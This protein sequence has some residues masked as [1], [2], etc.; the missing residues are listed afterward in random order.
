MDIKFE[1]CSRIR[2]VTGS[3]TNSTKQQR[4]KFPKDGNKY[5]LPLV[6][7]AE[8]GMIKKVAIPIDYTKKS[9]W[10]LRPEF[11]TLY[12]T[13]LS[14]TEILLQIRSILSGGA[15]SSSAISRFNASRMAEF[16]AH[17]LPESF[18]LRKKEISQL[19]GLTNF[20]DGT[21]S[22][23]KFGLVEMRVGL[24]IVGQDEVV[25]LLR[26]ANSDPSAIEHL[27]MR[28]GDTRRS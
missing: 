1:I 26:A 21:I 4:R 19:I 3:I 22:E 13:D 10:S 11:Q 2:V 18:A 23:E 27:R 5:L 28:L 20:L 16:V 6:L 7:S 24:E 8:I 12:I 25:R 15:A 9:R 14:D 17:A